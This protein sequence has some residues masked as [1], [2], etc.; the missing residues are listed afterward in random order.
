MAAAFKHT[1]LLS[2]VALSFQVSTKY[3]FIDGVPPCLNDENVSGSLFEASAEIIGSD[4]LFELKPTLG[5]EDFAFF[6]QLIPGS[7][8]R[9]GCSNKERGF[10][11][12]LHS[13]HFDIDENVLVIG[14]DIFTEAIK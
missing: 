6:N 12:K 4:N 7:I 5:G 13:P 8:M 10:V 2:L 14:V 3:Q 1:L 11:H 9:L